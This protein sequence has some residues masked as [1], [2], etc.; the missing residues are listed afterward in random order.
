LLHLPLS[1]LK[2]RTRYFHYLILED[3]TGRTLIEQRQEKDIWRELYQFPLVE[4]TNS[5][6]NINGL[7]METEWPDWLPAGALEYLRTS[8]P[9]KQQ[10]T[11]Q[12]IITT[13]HHFGWKAMPR[14]LKGKTVTTNKKLNKFA[15]PRVITRY[16]NE[17]SLTLDLFNQQ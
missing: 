3:E 8:R 10:L 13:F 1:Q 6:L 14:S 16:L 11:H 4:T 12:T 2:K 15:F 17:E 9:L 7:A 5:K